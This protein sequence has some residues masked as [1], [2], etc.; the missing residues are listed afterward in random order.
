M[1]RDFGIVGIDGLIGAAEA[2]DQRKI[3]SMDVA[4]TTIDK[5]APTTVRFLRGRFDGRLGPSSDRLGS[6]RSRRDARAVHVVTNLLPVMWVND[7]G[8][9]SAPG[10][11]VTAL[12]PLPDGSVGD[13]IGSAATSRRGSWRQW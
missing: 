4:M 5:Q 13:W 7:V 8:W 3:A 11:L 1:R 6:G 9:R 10:G 12:L 2:P